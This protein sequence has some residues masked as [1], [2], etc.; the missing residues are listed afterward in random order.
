[1]S[2]SHANWA[3]VGAAYIDINIIGIHTNRFENWLTD[4][5]CMR[6]K[7]DRSTAWVQYPSHPKPARA[8]ALDGLAP[9]S[10]GVVRIQPCHERQTPVLVGDLVDL[11]YPVVDHRLRGIVPGVVEFVEQQ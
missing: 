6:I 11:A 10:Q 1:M 8:L 7:T 3:A 4:F 2:S 9:Q 5:D